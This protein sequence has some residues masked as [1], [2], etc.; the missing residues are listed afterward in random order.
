MSELEELE[1]EMKK[2]YQPNWNSFKKSK[3]CSEPHN[4]IY[5]NLKDNQNSDQTDEMALIRYSQTI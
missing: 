4:E 5:T 1:A 3:T 2:I